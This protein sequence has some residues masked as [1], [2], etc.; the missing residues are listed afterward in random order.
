MYEYA[1]YGQIAQDDHQR[2]LQQ[3]TGLTRMPP[4]PVQQIHLVFKAQ[5][6]AGVAKI[7]TA[8]DGSTKQDVQRI[9][10]MLSANLY[11]VHVIGEVHE[12]SISSLETN[13]D[14]TMSD[15]S[16]SRR[17]SWRLDFKDTPDPGKQAVSGR[18]VARVPLEDGNIVKFMKA[19]GYEYVA[20]RDLR[21]RQEKADFYQLRK[22]LHDPRPTIL[23]PGHNAARPPNLSNPL[24][25]CRRC[26]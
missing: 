3:L 8:G 10:K 12:S 7:P 1:L 11:F 25:H 5:P 17:I 26:N 15:G 9:V 20:M 6:P 14:A 22:P 4:Q 18:L 24:C 19:F 23:R 13:G 2:I 21:M 16:T